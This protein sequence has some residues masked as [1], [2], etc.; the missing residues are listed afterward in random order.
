MH[1]CKKVAINIVLD[2]ML[3][4]RFTNDRV[5]MNLICHIDT[6]NYSWVCR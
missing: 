3:I 2:I 4:E 5:L 1:Q 6:L